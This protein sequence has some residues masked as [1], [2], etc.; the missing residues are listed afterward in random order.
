MLGMTTRLRERRGSRGRASLRACEESVYDPSE[1]PEK[2]TGHQEQH[3]SNPNPPTHLS[4]QKDT[5][6]WT[7]S[8]DG[9]DYNSEAV[10][11]FTN[12]GSRSRWVGLSRC[13]SQVGPSLS[14]LA[15]LL[16]RRRAPAREALAKG[17]L[18]N[19]GEPYIIG[20]PAH[21]LDLL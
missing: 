2:S 19:Y 20:A 1:Q 3:N 4:L 17:I 11:A 21:L 9:P 13:W 10:E 5:S 12:S 7:K 18:S 6:T 16:L 14:H 8:Q 15:G